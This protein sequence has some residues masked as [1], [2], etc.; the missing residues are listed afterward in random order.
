MPR[1]IED[2]EGCAGSEEVGERAAQDEM[3]SGNIYMLQ[4]KRR[5]H[6]NGPGLEGGMVSAER[7][8]YPALDRCFA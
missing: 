6:C 4:S 2:G 1:G 7:A 5:R 8:G 3:I